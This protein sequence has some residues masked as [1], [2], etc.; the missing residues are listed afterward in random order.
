M[1]WYSDKEKFNEYD[2][3]YCIN[4]SGGN[5]Y[6]QCKKCEEVYKQEECEE[7]V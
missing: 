2:P 3:S 1:S 4:C 5:S 6:E 7:Q